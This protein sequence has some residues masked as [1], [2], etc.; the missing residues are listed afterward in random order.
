[1]FD[2]RTVVPGYRAF[3][4]AYAEGM[5]DLDAAIRA[6]FPTATAQTPD[7][8]APYNWLRDTVL[9]ALKLH[10]P[11]R[12]EP[13]LGRLCTGCANPASGHFVFDPCPTKRAIVERL[14]INAEPA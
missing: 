13:G 11:G 4:S 9:I 8:A 3:G 1:M 14:G 7:L 10:A 2:Y 6:K 12:E 5:T